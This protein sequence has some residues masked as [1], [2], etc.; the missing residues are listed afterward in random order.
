MGTVAS[1]EV[2][3]SWPDAW[4]RPIRQVLSQGQSLLRVQPPPQAPAS[5]PRRPSISAA[6]ARLFECQ[7]NSETP[8][9]L[10]EGRIFRDVVADQKHRDCE[11]AE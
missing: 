7:V 1:M 2:P 5:S 10:K 4:H 6:K 8:G 11:S 3:P 9:E